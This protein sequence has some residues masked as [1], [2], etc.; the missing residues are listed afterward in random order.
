[1]TSAAQLRSGHL[2]GHLQPLPCNLSEVEVGVL[3]NAWKM[4]ARAAG[5]QSPWRVFG[6]WV[7]MELC[8]GG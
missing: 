5:R 6:S 3:G 7:Q 8:G 2:R 4:R 1:M